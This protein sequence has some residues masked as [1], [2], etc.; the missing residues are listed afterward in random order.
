MRP[1]ARA[2][3]RTDEAARRTVAPVAVAPVALAPVA[4]A[5]VAVALVAIDRTSRC[6]NMSEGTVAKGRRAEACVADYLKAQ[7]LDILGRNVR[8]GRYEIDLLA[9]DGDTIAVVEVRSRGQNAWQTALQ[10]VSHAKRQRLRRAAQ[11]LW[12]D[13]FGRDQSVSRI[14]FDVAAVDLSTP[15][16][17]I[18][19]VRAAFT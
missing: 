13:R 15:D 11:M 17:P 3:R 14:R 2:R 1:S 10:S 4:V 8:V 12:T 7:G 19:Y 5:P 6:R 16:T 9:R 18:D